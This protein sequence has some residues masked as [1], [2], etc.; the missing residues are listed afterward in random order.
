MVSKEFLIKLNTIINTDGEY[1]EE[2]VVYI[3]ESLIQFYKTI[4]KIMNEYCYD[5][6]ITNTTEDI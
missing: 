1:S 6:N 2:E 3:G 5:E 4:Q